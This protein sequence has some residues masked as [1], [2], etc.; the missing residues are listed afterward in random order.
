[1]ADTK[2]QNFSLALTALLFI[3][4]DAVVFIANVA[5]AQSPLIP[6]DRLTLWNPGLNAIGGIP[7]RTIVCATVNA[8]SY[9]HGAQDAGPESKM[10]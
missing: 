1:M 8:S 7:Q 2:E 3:S 9:G 10:R 4:V 6:A 5:S